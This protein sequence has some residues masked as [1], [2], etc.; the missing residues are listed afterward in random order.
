M[1]YIVIIAEIMTIA[2][3]LLFTLMI[4]GFYREGL[5]VRRQ[6]LDPV[7][8]F[9]IANAKWAYITG[10]S[11]VYVGSIVVLYQFVMGN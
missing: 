3:F 4:D 9:F 11:V 7:V 2:W 1:A 5:T 8:T 10:I 6:V